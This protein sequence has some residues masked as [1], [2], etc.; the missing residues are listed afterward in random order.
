M[1]KKSEAFADTL[2]KELASKVTKQR[3]FGLSQRERQERLI[4]EV[5]EKTIGYL[6][7]ADR[8]EMVDTF[9]ETL[10]NGLHDAMNEAIEEAKRTGDYDHSILV[11][12]FDRLVRDDIDS[13]TD[14]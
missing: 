10:M 9:H 4:A 12:A 3:G 14:E 6:P 13:W 11:D 1:S 5:A 2:A 7:N 8:R